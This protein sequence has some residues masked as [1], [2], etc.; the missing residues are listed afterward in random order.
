MPISVVLQLRMASNVWFL[1]VDY[2]QRELIEM[3]S[4]P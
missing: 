3:S 4:M 2:L 1:L